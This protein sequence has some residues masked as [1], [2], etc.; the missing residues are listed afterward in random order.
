MCG[1]TLIISCSNN[2]EKFYV[3]SISLE[4]L[5]LVLSLAKRKLVNQRKLSLYSWGQLHFPRS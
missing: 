2:L 4:K 1:N 5:S 3:K